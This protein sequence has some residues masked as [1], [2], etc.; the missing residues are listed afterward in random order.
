[1]ALL[2]FGCFVDIVPGI[3][4]RILQLAYA[5]LDFALDFLA[6]AF[7]FGLGVAERASDM[8]LGA[9]YGLVDCTLY[10]VLVHFSPLRGYRI[11]KLC[12]GAGRLCRCLDRVTERLFD[13]HSPGPL[14]GII[15]DPEAV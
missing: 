12:G 6:G 13:R 3:A 15:G 14:P 9:S 4:S 1:M 8:T 2:A 10:S 11:L 7:Y 5:G